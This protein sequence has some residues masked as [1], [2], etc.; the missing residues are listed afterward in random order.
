M[1]WAALMCV[2]GVGGAVEVN[3]DSG[4]VGMRALPPPPPLRYPYPPHTVPPY[5]PYPPTTT[6]TT[7]TP[8]TPVLVSAV[9]ISLRWGVNKGERGIDLFIFTHS[10]VLG[11]PTPATP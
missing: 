9:R 7:P 3:S 1:G 5:S 8:K 11:C 2:S 4:Q 10:A 6:T